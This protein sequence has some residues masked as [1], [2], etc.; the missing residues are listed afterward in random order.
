MMCQYQSQ[1]IKRGLR[2][3]ARDVRAYLL[4]RQV[5]K[6]SPA[7]K[8]LS[9]QL[10]ASGLSLRRIGFLLKVSQVAVQRWLKKLI[11]ALCP[12][13]EPQGRILVM[14]LDEM[15]HHLHS[16]KQTLDLEGLLSAYRSTH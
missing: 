8:L 10:Y 4:L 9:L 12:K 6:G 1:S 15:W 3:S 2:W 11:P 5:Y 14:E 7:M 13:L 16:K